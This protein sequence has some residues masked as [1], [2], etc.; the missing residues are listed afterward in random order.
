MQI[1]LPSNTKADFDNVL[2]TQKPTV[3]EADLKVYEKFTEEYVLYVFVI[4]MLAVLSMY[5]VSVP[6]LSIVSWCSKFDIIY[7]MTLQ[8]NS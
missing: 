5:L 7:N 6:C 8:L 1:Q 4:H 3:S 2:A